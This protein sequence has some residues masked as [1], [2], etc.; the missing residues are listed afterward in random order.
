VSVR[1]SFFF[2]Q[3]ICMAAMGIDIAIRGPVSG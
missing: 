1:F 3:F 2:V